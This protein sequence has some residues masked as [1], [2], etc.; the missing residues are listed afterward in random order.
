MPDDYSIFHFDFTALPW[1][2]SP[3]RQ[4]ELQ[5]VALGLIKI[6]PSQG[7]TF[8]HRHRE[9][10]E[11]YIV[12]EGGGEILVGNDLVPLRPGDLVR[13]APATRR[14][15]KAGDTGLFVIC[16]GAIPLGFPKHPQSRYLIDDGIPDYDDLPPWYQGD[17]IASENNARLKQRFLA[18]KRKRKAKE[19]DCS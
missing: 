12:I 3:R 5:G 14:A 9:Q 11:V 1:L 17:T 18:A 19:R 13:V 4:L 8:T 7:Y 15:L 10:E 2:T 6:P 16:A